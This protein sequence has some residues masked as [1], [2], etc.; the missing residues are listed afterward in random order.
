[1]AC[2]AY[3]S[4]TIGDTANGLITNHNHANNSGVGITVKQASSTDYRISCNTGTGSSRTY[5]TYYGTTNIK[6]AWHHL[7]LTYSASAKQLKL[8]VDGNVEYTLNNYTNGAAANPFDLFNWST[9]HYTNGDYRPVCKL[10]DVR[11]YDNCLSTKEVKMLAMGLVAHYPLSDSALEPTTNLVTSLS[12]GGQTT[13]S[14]DGLSVTSSGANSDTYFYMNLSE[15][16]V[17]NTEYTI[18]C[19]VSGMPEN[20]SWEFPIGAQSNTALSWYLHNGHNVKTFIANDISW[21]NKVIMDDLNGRASCVGYN[22]TFSH[23][24]IEKKNHETAYVIGSRNETTVH[25][26]SGYNYHG[27]INTAQKVDTDTAKYRFSTV[28][29][30]DQNAIII[31]FNNM[32][33][34]ATTGVS[35]TVS[36]WTYKSSIGTK[37]YQTIL[38]GPSGFE[39]EARN[40]SS[41]DPLY[42]LWNWGKGTAAYE[43]NKW[44]LFTFVHTAS[45]SKLY[46]N[47][48]LKV[49]GSTAAIPSGNFYIG[50]WNSPSQ[51]NYEGKMSDFRIYVTALTA[52]QVKE[53]YQASASVIN[54]G[55]L[56]AYEFVEK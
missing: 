23:F 9:G 6:D 1:M 29:D 31:P 20:G 52:D 38:G 41:A 45:D 15:A 42:A 3:V 46:V 43:L 10:N 28:F 17:K 47:G 55:T 21:S 27:T 35:Y 4:A 32:L 48:E 14:A 2:W 33:G 25:D 50:S 36:V 51:Q 13:L 16:I 34:G 12:A 19:D 39:L 40:S 24:Q 54:N 30:G 7:A 5:M 26:S 18:S 56:A 11:L 37:N 49:T 53:L 44:T 22:V 8:W